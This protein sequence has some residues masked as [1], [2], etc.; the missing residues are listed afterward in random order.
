MTI[1]MV[2]L[3]SKAYKASI[4]RKLYTYDS[5]NPIEDTEDARKQMKNVKNNAKPI[6]KEIMAR[7]TIS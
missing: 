1:F 2:Y 7:K 6:K 4:I 3:S 5:W